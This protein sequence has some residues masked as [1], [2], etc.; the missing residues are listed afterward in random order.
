MVT[1][2]SDVELRQLQALVAVAE[3][4]T[5]GRAAERLGFSQSAVSQQ[6]AALERHMGTPAFLRPGGPR[7]VSLTPAGEVML[8]VAESVVERLRMADVE[9]AELGSV[10]SGKV[11][12]GSFQS[13]TVALLPPTLVRM[14]RE[15][16]SVRVEPIE[17]DEDDDLRRALRAA[18]IDLAFILGR[19][20]PWMDG[21]EVL[22]DPLVLVTPRAWEFPAVVKA[23]QLN[24]LSMV[25]ESTGHC[26]VVDDA[27]ATIGAEPHVVFRTGDNGAIQALVRA[28]MGAAV[29]PLLA[30]EL[31]D[32]EVVLH[33][34]EPPLAPRIISLV[35]R[36]SEPRSRAAQ[37]FVDAVLLEAEHLSRQR[38]T[39][40]ALR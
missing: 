27:V 14:R 28:G 17:I 7:P 31:S 1:V 36:A 6:V 32:R 10:D 26:S 23:D 13:V 8:S 16:P 29:M 5:F 39:L 33:E 3:E 18:E 11:S 25:G 15:R 9:L 24:G 30:V 20:E 12:V 21:V 4:G 22:V 40:N 37:A 34:T 19:P 2:I 38:R 35:S